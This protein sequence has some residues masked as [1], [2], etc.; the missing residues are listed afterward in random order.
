MYKYSSFER[1]IFGVFIFNKYIIKS[2]YLSIEKGTG[3]IL[4]YLAVI[5]LVIGISDNYFKLFIKK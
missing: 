1:Y 5:N 3:S 2:K 4:D